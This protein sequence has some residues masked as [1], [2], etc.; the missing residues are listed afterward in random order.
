MIAAPSLHPDPVGSCDVVIAIM[1]PVFWPG[2]RS[3]RVTNGGLAF[4][5]GDV[6]ILA[7]ASNVG[8]AIAV[9]ALTPNLRASLNRSPIWWAASASHLSKRLWG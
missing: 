5:W 8:P 9:G 2:Q 6:D 7:E 3:A 4:V 1:R